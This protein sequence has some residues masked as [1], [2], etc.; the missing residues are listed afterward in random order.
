MTDIDMDLDS[1]M[2]PAQPDE[3]RGQVRARHAASRHSRRV[4][5]LKILLPIAGVAIALV[6]A[7]IVALKSFLPGINMP[8]V[9]FSKDGLTMVE[10]RLSGRAKNRA[11]DVTAARAYQSLDNPKVVTLEKIDGRIEMPDQTWAKIEAKH[12]RYDGTTQ[13]LVLDEGLSVVTSNGYRIEGALANVDLDSGRMTSDRPVTI[14]GPAGRIEAGG[15]DVTDEGHAIRFTGGVRMNLLP[16]PAKP[17]E[18]AGGPAFRSNSAEA[19]R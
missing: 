13:K 16:V 9:L 11:Y 15:V 3:A 18:P 8:G 7:A 19:G 10:P 14:D 4:R 2:V 1:R 6:V 12:G 17:G 5:L